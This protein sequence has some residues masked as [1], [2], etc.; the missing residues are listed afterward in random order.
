MKK[1]R[2]RA[3]S[4]HWIPCCKWLR[5]M[6][7]LGVIMVG[8]CLSVHANAYSQQ[9]KITLEMN[10]RSLKEVFIEICRQTNLEILF[11]HNLVEGIAVDVKAKNK[12]L[13]E[14]L[15]ELLPSLGLEYFR[16][17]SVIV[18]R[19]QQPSTQQKEYLIKGKVLDHKKQ[20]LPGVTV[21]VEGAVSTGTA[22]ARD[23][24]FTLRLPVERGNLI[25]SFIGFK[26]QTVTFETGKELEIT[27]Q[28][29]VSNLDEVTVVAYGT[30]TK[31]EMTGSVSVIKAEELEGIPSPSIATLLQGRVA[32]MD[33]TNVSGAPG[34]GGTLV[35]IRGYNS[36]DMEQ[37]RRFSNPLWV[38]D[39][40]P[41]NSFT[42]PVTGT[43]MLADLN[44]DMIESIQV[45]K[46]ASSAAIYGSRAANGVIVVTTKQGRK[47][48]D[49]KF[50][51]NVSHSWSM[52]PE[53]PTI[54]VGKA[55]RDF[56]LAALKNRP[57]AYLDEAKNMYIYPTTPKEA[58]DH[59]GWQ[60]GQDFFQVPRNPVQAN[61]IALQDSL[62]SFYNNQSNFF[63]M[64]YRTGKVLNAN[65]QTYGGSERISYG[66]GLGYYD[67]KG[68]VRGSGFSRINLNT[69]LT[70]T[71]VEKLNIDLRFYASISGRNRGNK[72]Q[73][74][75]RYQLETIPGDPYLLS[76][77]L[78]GEGSVV[79]ENILSKL[80]GIQEK[81]RSVRTRA[82][83]KLGYDLLPGV[84][85]S[86][87]LSADYA[88]NRRNQFTPS[89]LNANGYSQSLGETGIDLMVLNE[90][91][92]AIKR[93]VKE[94]H[95]LN[96]VAGLSYQYDQMESNKGYA[97]NSPSDK[98]QYAPPG[99]PSL[100]EEE[101]YG[102]K[103]TIAFKSYESDM[104]EKAMLSYFARLE[105]NYKMKYLI[106][107]SFRRD[108]S[109]VFG[110]DNRWGTFPSIAGAW[111]FSE[112]SWLK[113]YL[114][115]LDFGKIRT[116]WGRSGMV[117][118]NNYLALG[119][120]Q[121][122]QYPHLGNPTVEPE[123]NNGLY[124]DALS[125]EETDQYDFGV[126]IDLFNYRLGLVVDYYYRYTDKLLATV[127]IPGDYTGYW[128]QWR[129]AA[130]VSNEGLEVLVKYDIFK[131]ENLFWKVSVNAARNWNRFEK[132]YNGR[133]LDN[134][135]IGK[136]LN[137]IYGYKTT[138]FFDS[139]EEIPIVQSNAGSSYL[140]PINKKNQYKPGT[141]S[142]V[143]VN[144]DGIISNP[145]IVYLASALPQVSGGIISELQWRNFDLSMSWAFQ[146]NRHIVNWT[147][148]NAITTHDANYMHPLLLDLN[149]T[150]FWEKPGDQADYEELRYG[151]GTVF[152]TSV[153]RHVEKVNV[154]KL[155]TL[156]LGYNLKTAWTKRAN[157][158]QI[159][160]FVS[161]ENLLNWTNYSGLDP[162]TVDI[163]TGIDRGDNYPLA[164]KITLGL[165]VKF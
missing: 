96:F 51:V 153:D 40:V 137:G 26:A 139:V 136:P 54:T 107:A 74:S 87:S 53:L 70:V 63:P 145:D 124:N 10:Q 106:S 72:S 77:L 44:P 38:V 112:E 18:I 42:S 89:Y 21:R 84:N 109:S 65:I 100:G 102:S 31:R 125:W 75:Y 7:I 132:S 45:L 154:L 8:F 67:E 150:T 165:T 138:G 120:M 133:D 131:K 142:F 58:Y 79:W 164:R 93:T 27:L 15:E 13:S 22:T 76:S 61:G 143:D 122:G 110:K 159:R 163:T 114:P 9:E 55:E 82:N 162:E 37:A 119:I 30:T 141:Y 81:N 116:S 62:N 78:P 151:E 71:P 85:L 118:S 14:V 16:D 108:G 146:L 20:P 157:M 43:N 105:Y 147:P 19:A 160:F 49:A 69:N 32:G 12:E 83:F 140:Y 41:L 115:W 57:V 91:L 28:E 4:N 130:A 35:T 50:S 29:D 149:K 152:I 103:R 60:V 144:G 56:R 68:I 36:L 135:I 6:K 148:L 127:P 156:V 123:W 117:F 39:G 86:S 33:I 158:E 92:L 52:L 101:Y 64:Y 46:D 155:K 97:Q 128:S 59:Y 98:I 104:Q 23:G 95:N 90:N 161:G 1:K 88:V 17:G 11:N 121:V 47:N 5:V 129:N 66:I 99:L 134:F 25:F 2:I 73:N 80:N 94:N 34:A 48:Q 111:T 24:S 113:E 126:D 3:W